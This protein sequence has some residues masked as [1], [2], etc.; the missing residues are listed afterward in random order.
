MLKLRKKDNQ[1]SEKTEASEKPDLL[2]LFHQEECRFIQFAYGI[3]GQREIAEEMVQEMFSRLHEHWDEVDR[4]RPWAYRALRN[5]C[6]SCLRDRKRKGNLENEYG[7][8]AARANEEPDKELIRLE[9]NGMVRLFISE[10]A[11]KDQEL[12][13]LKYTE[14]VSYAEIAKRT[15]LSISNVG[16]RLHHIV[17]SLSDSLRRTGMTGNR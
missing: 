9:T 16:Y 8:L 7:E 2:D 14:C 11:E 4:P 1:R 10:L 3:V 17:R 5:L 12:I 13:N 15:G 6:I